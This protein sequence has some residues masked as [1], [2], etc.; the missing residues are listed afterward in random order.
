MVVDDDDPIEEGKRRN[1][2]GERCQVK[3]NQIGTKSKSRCSPC[4]HIEM[5]MH[6]AIYDTARSFPSSVGFRS[7]GMK[8]R[9]VFLD[10]KNH[11]CMHVLLFDYLPHGI[12]V[13]VQYQDD[14]VEEVRYD[15]ASDKTRQSYCSSQHVDDLWRPNK[16]QRNR[17]LILSDTDNHV[18][19]ERFDQKSKKY[20]Q[21]F[22]FR[23]AI[24]TTS[25]LTG[26]SKLRD[27]FLG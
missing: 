17:V 9:R 12:L 23:Q 19:T 25:S 20:D 7:S 14:I 18:R 15:N 5:H 3:S 2:G 13:V 16:Q 6:D 26:V 8:R 24:W 1:P 11:A 21:L 27:I 22:K 4:H 10:H